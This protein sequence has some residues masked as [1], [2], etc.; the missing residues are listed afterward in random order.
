M[1]KIRFLL[2]EHI[3]RA[4][5]QALRRRGIDVLTAGEAALLGAPDS[6]YLARSFS[7]GRVLVTQ[8]GDFQGLHGAGRAHVGIA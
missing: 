3:P 6:E 7:D 2:G 1:D 4:V 8:D 5:A